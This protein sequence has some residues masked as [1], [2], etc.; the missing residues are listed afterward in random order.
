MISLRNC[1]EI[2]VSEGFLSKIVACL[3]PWWECVPWSRFGKTGDVCLV[4][5]RQRS[6]DGSRLIRQRL[7]KLFYLWP[8]QA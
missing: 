8:E 2:R 7:K 4:R 6:G 1:V 3:T 5:G